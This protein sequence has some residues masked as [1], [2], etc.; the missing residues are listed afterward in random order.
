M[1]LQAFLRPDVLPAR[2][3]EVILSDRFRDADGNPVPL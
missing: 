2:E 3:T 1:D